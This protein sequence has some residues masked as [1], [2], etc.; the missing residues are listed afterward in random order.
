[1]V[2]LPPC[3]MDNRGIER[4]A[5]QREGWQ[6]W[7]WQGHDCHYIS[8]GKQNSGPIV[9]LVHGFGAHSYHWRYTIPMLARKGFR[10]FALCMLGY[11]WSPK[12]EE[13]YCM[14]LWGQQVIDFSREVA[15]ASAEDQAVI[16][17]NSIGALAALYAASK[18]QEQCMGLCLVN[19]AGNF[20]PGAPAGPER[21][22]AAQQAMRMVDADADRQKGSIGQRMREL[23]GKAMTTG[24]FYFTKIRIKQILQQVRLSTVKPSIQLRLC[25]ALI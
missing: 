12:V 2:E 20:E 4:L 1:M 24:I 8:A 15:G 16:A 18:A 6:R 21:N 22:T 3:E 23:V 10:V 9:V 14:E 13:K 5:F 11:G 25:L 19:S 7:K 17:G